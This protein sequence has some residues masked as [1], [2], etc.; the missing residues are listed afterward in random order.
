MSKMS[1]CLVED[2]ELLGETLCDRFRIEGLSFEWFKQGRPAMLS[3]ERKRYSLVLCDLRLPDVSGVDVFDSL[4]ADTRPPFVF[5]TAFGSIDEAVGLLKAGA[6]DFVTK[7]FDLDQLM[8]RVHQFCMPTSSS[9]E[10]PTLGLSPSMRKIEALVTRLAES[11]EPMLVSGESGSG[12][13]VVARLLHDRSYSHRG[14]EWVP[15]NCAAIPEGLIEAELFG[16]VRGA[17]TGAAR[18]HRGFIEQAN[19]GTLFLDEIGDMPLSM[20]G[21]LLRVLQERKVTRIGAESATPVDF[22]LISATH[23]D[24]PAMVRA[25]H[26]REDLYYRINVI[27]VHVPPLRD[28]REDI[29]W[30]ADRMLTQLRRPGRQRALTLSLPAQQALFAHGWPGNVRELNHVLRR[31]VALGTGPI[32]E[33]IDLFPEAAE[34]APL[35]ALQGTAWSLNEHL[36][37]SERAFLMTALQ[38]HNGAIA[39]AAAGLGISRKTLW[40]KM[41]RHGID[42]QQFGEEVQGT[43]SA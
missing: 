32:V 18:A 41:R 4:D 19:G 36:E 14:G 1:I 9:R 13:E 15:V 8:V 3:L 35:S 12:K 24:L 26:F 2:D 30:L 42:K 21:R 6:I 22:R 20:Q 39:Q 38:R 34:S 31:A 40:E 10:E 5:M 37:Q 25:G 17:F 11:L 16:Y 43:A 7:P 33:A 28:R 23:R 29:I 27:A